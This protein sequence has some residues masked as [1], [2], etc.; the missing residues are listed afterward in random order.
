LFNRLHKQSVQIQETKKWRELEK[1]QNDLEKCTFIPNLEKYAGLI[2]ANKTVKAISN[3][4]FTMFDTQ[5]KSSKI[6]DY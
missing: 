2:N 3:A 1:E 4:G 5:S 6:K